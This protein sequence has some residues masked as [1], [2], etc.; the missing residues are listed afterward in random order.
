MKTSVAKTGRQ[1]EREILL[2]ACSFSDCCETK[3]AMVL[4]A[5]LESPKHFYYLATCQSAPLPCRRVCVRVRR[6]LFWAAA[7]DFCAK[8]EKKRSGWSIYIFGR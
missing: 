7:F 5:S 2:S 4:L 3:R 6:R 8:S 1:R